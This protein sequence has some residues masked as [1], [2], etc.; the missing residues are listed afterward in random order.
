MAAIRMYWWR[1][2][3]NFGDV[4]APVIVAAIC[5]REPVWQR[6]PPRLLAIGS[7]LQRARPGD[8]I[9]GSGVHDLRLNQPWSP[10]GVTFLAV[11][12]PL[13]RR[14][15]LDCGGTCP[16][17]YGDPASLLPKFHP[18]PVEPTRELAL[19]PHLVDAAGRKFA[20]QQGLP[21]IEPSWPWPRVVAEIV[22]CRLLLSSSLHGV[23]VAEAYGV[24]AIWVAHTASPEKFHDYYQTTG[25]RHGEPIPWELA[26]RTKPPELP[27]RI[28]DHG[29]EAALREWLDCNER[30]KP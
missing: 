12:G 4:L 23:I 27:E 8:T 22:A 19:M 21:C 25:R 9:W 24:P 29:L 16:P 20:R 7:I 15:I 13:T 11:R 26:V 3:L 1:E 17:V 30:N 2:Q 18:L 14:Y 6:Q 5:G 10:V 28:T